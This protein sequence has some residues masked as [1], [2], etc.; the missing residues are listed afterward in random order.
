MFAVLFQVLFTDQPVNRWDRG[1]FGF[2]GIM[3]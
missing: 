3:R 1:P 2:P